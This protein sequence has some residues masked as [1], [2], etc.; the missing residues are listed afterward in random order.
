MVPPISLSVLLA[1]APPPNS[2]ALTAEQVAQLNAKLSVM[3]HNVNN[4]LA[5]IVAATELIRRKPDT[6]ER[7]IE[8]IVQQPDRIMDEMRSF[9]T[10]FETSLKIEKPVPDF[11]SMFSLPAS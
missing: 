9:S 2:I 7:F 6:V 10:E 4:C 5:L 1:M 3:R 11:A 8:N